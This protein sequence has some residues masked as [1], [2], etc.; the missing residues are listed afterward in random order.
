[1][2]REYKI[3]SKLVP[4][5]GPQ[6]NLHTVIIPGLMGEERKV[7]MLTVSINSYYL[8]RLG[9]FL[10]AAEFS[11]IEEQMNFNKSGMYISLNYL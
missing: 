7:G 4:S 2:L 3:V 5:R 1:M 10:W 8:S 11:K 9:N 6:I